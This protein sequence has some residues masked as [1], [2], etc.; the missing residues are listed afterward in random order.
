MFKYAYPVF[1]A[2]ME[3]KENVTGFF[4]ANFECE[5]KDVFLHICA[6]SYYRVTVNGDTACHGKIK[7]LLR[8]F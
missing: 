3:E 6:S 4:A 5:G 8:P 2:G 7:K 1:L